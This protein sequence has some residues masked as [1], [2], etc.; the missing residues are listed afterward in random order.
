M[1]RSAAAPP[2]K[3][4]RCASHPMRTHRD[5]RA[6]PS[7]C[8]PIC[9]RRP[10]RYSQN[11]KNMP[12]N[13]ARTPLGGPATPAPARLTPIVRPAVGGICPCPKSCCARIAAPTGSRAAKPWRICSMSTIPSPL[14]GSPPAGRASRNNA[15]PRCRWAARRA[16]RACRT[17]PRWGC[18]K[19][20]GAISP[21]PAPPM[22]L[23][24]RRRCSSR[25]PAIRAI[26]PAFGAA[27]TR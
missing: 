4:L 18:S 5:V 6:L 25:I 27:N 23:A 2:R 10:A 12:K 7:P 26:T 24:V 16:R 21:L 1:R 3:R 11:T 14:A 9:Q 19:K 17:A 20:S 15:L 13:V 8:R 22:P